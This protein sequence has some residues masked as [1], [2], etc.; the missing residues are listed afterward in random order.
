MFQAQGKIVVGKRWQSERSRQACEQC[1]ALDGQEFYFAPGPGQRSISEM[2]QAPLHPNCRCSVEDI[3]DYA[4]VMRE[5]NEWGEDDARQPAEDA[6]APAERL[7]ESH[8]ISPRF[9]QG[10]KQAL[11]VNWCNDGRKVSDGPNYGNW[12][13]QNWGGG[14]N[15]TGLNKGKMDELGEA[16]KLLEPIDKMD[17]FFKDHDY[18]YLNI[19]PDDD[20]EKAE[21]DCNQQLINGLRSLPDDPNHPGWGDKHK[22]EKEVDY[23]RRM[24]AYATWCFEGRINWY[25]VEQAEDPTKVE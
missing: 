8:N 20:R 15:I 25:V 23:A 1:R 6:P 7:F 12:G 13:G 18:C 21:F 5:Q 16:G 22:N 14:M 4:K 9:H 24:R 2:P 10:A 19:G 17:D 11:G 3:L